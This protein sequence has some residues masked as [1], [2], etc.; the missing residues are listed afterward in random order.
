MRS[1]VLCPVTIFTI[2]VI[3]FGAPSGFAAEPDAA[4]RAAVKLQVATWEDVQKVVAGAKG[5]VVVLDLWSTACEPCMEEFPHLVKLQHQHADTVCISFSVDFAG[6]RN[7]PPEFYRERVEVFLAG[8]EASGV[9]NY[10]C[11]QPADELF[12]K[13]DLDSIPAVYVYDRRG[14]LVKRFDNR[15][16]A[17]AGAEGISYETQVMPLVSELVKRK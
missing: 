1:C 6:I 3:A 11:S 17:K 12:E 14:K 2:A 7:K 9:R 15:T 16:P 5:K 13:I 8:Q 10:L 4:A